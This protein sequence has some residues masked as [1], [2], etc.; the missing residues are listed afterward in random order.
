[1]KLSTPEKRLL[2]FAREEFGERLTEF[3]SAGFR[4]NV[5]SQRWRFT[6]TYVGDNNS[7]LKRHVEIITYEPEDGSSYLPRRRDPMVLLALLYLLLRGNSES[8]NILRYKDE[9]VLGLLGWKDT[10][11]ARGE[12]DRAIKRYFQLT[13]NWKMNQEE[14]AGNGLTYYTSQESIINEHEIVDG[15]AAQENRIVFNAN[16]IELLL[17][18]SSFGID[19]TTVKSVSRKPIKS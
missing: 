17:R 12:M 10:E 7:L 3:F 8:S 11:K 14:L 5:D 6:I 16:F 9:D 4:E 18:R 1:M 19:W 13:Y 15:E 2:D